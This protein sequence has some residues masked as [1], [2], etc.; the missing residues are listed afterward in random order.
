MRFFSWVATVSGKRASGGLPNSVRVAKNGQDDK[1]AG[2]KVNGGGAV[3]AGRSEN[4]HRQVDDHPLT[5]G[6]GRAARRPYTS[7]WPEQE[8]H[9]RSHAQ[10]L[11]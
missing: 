7:H 10:K 4:N 3:M 8:R 2:W 6:L 5:G 9:F 1:L 11:C